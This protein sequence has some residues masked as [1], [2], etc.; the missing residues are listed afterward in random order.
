[1]A[2][3]ESSAMLSL[4]KEFM[5][6]I[7]D[8]KGTA[9]EKLR[10]HVMHNCQTTSERSDESLSHCI[11]GE[12][13]S[14]FLKMLIEFGQKKAHF[15]VQINEVAG[16]LEKACVMWKSHIAA[17][18]D[19]LHNLL[20][21]SSSKAPPE[22]A[23]NSY[24]QLQQGQS[25]EIVEGVGK[26]G[27]LV[28]REANG[29]W[30]VELLDG[31][32]CTAPES[33]LRCLDA[34]SMPRLMESA[35]GVKK[36]DEHLRD[37]LKMLC[38]HE[39]SEGRSGR[40]NQIR[41]DYTKDWDRILS[42]KDLHLAFAGLVSTG[43]TTLVN[44]LLAH[45]IPGHWNGG[46]LPS[47][48]EE[49]TR[50]VTMIAFNARDDG[51]VCVR[52]EAVHM[53]RKADQTLGFDTTE[54]APST[55]LNSMK[56]LQET[57]P[58]LLDK[59]T[60]SADGF[61]RLIVELPHRLDVVPGHSS[62]VFVDTPGLDSVGLKN[63]LVSILAQKC[64]LYC[65]LVDVASPAPFG[66]QGFEMLQ[67]LTRNVCNMFP[68]VI[69]F[70]KFNLLKESSDRPS[71]KLANPQGLEG[72]LKVL[73]NSTLEKL[74]DAGVPS[75]PF[76][77]D[78]DALWASQDWKN[79]PESKEDIQQAQ[80]GLSEFCKDLVFLGR[81]IA[82]SLNH[83]MM[84]QSQTK[85]AQLIIN[86]I[87]REDGHRLLQVNDL[88]DMK[89]LG[90]KIKK[91]FSENVDQYFRVEWTE[92]GLREYHPQPLFGESCAILRIR[93]E[94][95]KEC[96]NYRLEN[97]DVWKKRQAVETIV[98][99]TTKTVLDLIMSDLS[100]YEIAALSNLK[101]GLQAKMCLKPDDLQKHLQSLWQQ[102]VGG[103]LGGGAALGWIG[104]V[105]GGTCVLLGLGAAQ[106]ASATAIIGAG[107][108]V[109]AGAGWSAWMLKDDFGGW[110]WEEARKASWEAVLEVCEKNCTQIADYVKDR[111]NEKIDD[112]LTHVE[113]HRIAPQASDCQATKMQTLAM[114][115]R[116]AA[117]NL[118]DDILK[119]K[120]RWL[121]KKGSKMEKICQEVLQE[122]SGQ[123]S[124]QEE[125]RL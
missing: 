69:I 120:K 46:M 124:Q 9:F 36:V 48:P 11:C 101:E 40:F 13:M 86:E 3:S 12:T 39:S 50:A 73:V 60:S 90:E 66:K 68:P 23:P 38:I 125:T 61:Q 43:K 6:A 122:R 81:S 78:V 52:T 57:I 44:S 24:D 87:C 97:P 30:K 118:L 47:A 88:K 2:S 7:D 91:K 22:R 62:E 102:V 106:I 108:G 114:E 41:C 37:L 28:E 72:H 17:F 89:T 98:T 27:K 104:G 96:E 82:T 111:L 64:F 54:V 1:M 109:L 29:H 20:P 33:R 93:A 112:I 117:R 94:F 19:K 63:H 8:N 105:S 32:T 31:N 107:V 53:T 95:E 85:T 121:G 49:N 123:Q 100:K 80:E 5:N 34:D 119:G 14:S 65:F 84:L 10:R 56:E 59:L 26:F 77:A 115:R 18:R 16:I 15:G 79:S 67:F 55:A 42:E 25:V 4:L 21:R 83:Y 45:C 103:G 58:S 110:T 99:K 92:A 75:Y 76:F 116:E 71:W 35:R 70:T 51:K 74:K 113:D